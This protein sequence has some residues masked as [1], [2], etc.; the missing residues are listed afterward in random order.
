MSIPDDCT[1]GNRSYNR[2][3]NATA[4]PSSRRLSGTHFF[5]WN[6]IKSASGG[7]SPKRYFSELLNRPSKRSNGTGIYICNSGYLCFNEKYSS[8]TPTSSV[9]LREYAVVISPGDMLR[10]LT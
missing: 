3:L 10:D 9:T 7:S 6:A 5:G 4:I 8:E 2:S 1:W